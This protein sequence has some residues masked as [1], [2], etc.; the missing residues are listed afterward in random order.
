MTVYV[1]TYVCMCVSIWRP[2]VNFQYHSS[3][4][5]HLDS[6]FLSLSQCMLVLCGVHTYVYGYTFIHVHVEARE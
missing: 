2:E 1:Y 4:A 3:S 5:F 6:L